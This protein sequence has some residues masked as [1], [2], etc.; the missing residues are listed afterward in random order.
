MPRVISFIVLL[1]IV[2]LVGAVFFQ[3]MAQFIV[4]LFLAAVLLVVFKPLHRRILTRLPKNPRVSALRTGV[5]PSECTHAV[6]ASTTDSPPGPG[7]TSTSF[8]TD[9]GLKK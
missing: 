8:I 3:V 1:A 9:A 5:L 2:L 4:P 6:A 7:T